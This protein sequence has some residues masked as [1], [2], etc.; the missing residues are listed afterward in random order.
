MPLIHNSVSSFRARGK[1]RLHCGFTLLE[2]MIVL[3]VMMILMAVALPLYQH[4]IIQAREAVLQQ[5]LD[6]LRRV[7]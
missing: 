5:N 7:L 6:T 4:H 3:S 2:L 1:A